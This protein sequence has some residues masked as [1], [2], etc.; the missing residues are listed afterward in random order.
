MLMGIDAGNHEVK[1]KTEAGVW[2]FLSDLGE[3]RELKISQP[4]GEDDMVFEYDGRRGFAGSLARYESEFVGSMMGLSKAHEDAKLRVLLAVHRHAG[5]AR[6]VRIVVG[7]PIKMH[8]DEEKGRIKRMLE[9]HHNMKVNGVE[10]R[11]QIERV[12]VAA[13]GGASF[14]ANPIM[15]KHRFV[16]AG[17][18]TVNCATILNKRYID[19]ESDTLPFGVNTNKTNDTASLARAI[20][21]ECSKKWQTGDSVY[22]VG[23]SAEALEEPFKRYFPNAKAMSPMTFVDGVLRPVHP[24]YTNAI[25]FYEI[26]RR[27]FT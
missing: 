8:I 26:G 14:W 19:R 23:G 17:S 24:V 11:F 4:H 6:L 22:L 13:E 7:Q 16:D 15:G 3:S 9:G 12:E 18:G 2:K 5:D 1:V 20:A 25:G 21:T 27:L 10:K